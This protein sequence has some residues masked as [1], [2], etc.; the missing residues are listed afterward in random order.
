MALRLIQMYLPG[1]ERVELEALLEEHRTVDQRQLQ[2]DEGTTLLQIL[3]EAESAEGV[4]DLL[5]GRFGSR[6]GAR[7]LLLPVE[8]ALPRPEPPEESEEGARTTAEETGAAEEATAEAEEATAEAEEAARI[9]R[10]ELYAD[11]SDSTRLTR[12]Y[13]VMVVLASVVAALGLLR[14]DIAVVIGAMVIAPLLGPNVALALAT[15]LGD[16]DLA[17]RALIV[18]AAGL[19]IALAV[20]VGLGI[21]LEVDPT[22]PAIAS[23][24]QVDLTDIG[25][26]LASGSAGALAFTSGLAAAVVGVMVA[27]ALL[28][29]LV[30]GGL[31]LGSGQLGL[32]LGAALLLLTNIIC[33]NLAGVTTFLAQG[34]RPATWWEADRA[35]RATRIAVAIWMILLAI[36][37]AAIVLPDGWLPG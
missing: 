37:I 33:V 23:R 1:D 19:G 14:D 7:I 34:I 18:N 5:E 29:P 12:V 15:T 26:A 27:V 25:L 10:E 20:S 31:L 11:A 30:V 9:S 2:V 4:L 32:G 6:E 24:T 36:L 17:W 3:V 8:A 35:R 16:G 21:G 13:Q 28:P 22:V